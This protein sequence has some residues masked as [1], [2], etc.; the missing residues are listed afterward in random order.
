MGIRPGTTAILM[1]ISR[2]GQKQPKSP[3]ELAVIAVGRGPISPAIRHQRLFFFPR[4]ADFLATFFVEVFAPFFFADFTLLV[5]TALF[6]AALF[7]DVGDLPPPKIAVQLSANF[8]VAPTRVLL[9]AKL[10]P[11][12]ELK[13]R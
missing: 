5:A 12:F 4:A 6:F 1:K 9:I 2:N 11:T 8:F 13:S 7:E 3:P 10:S